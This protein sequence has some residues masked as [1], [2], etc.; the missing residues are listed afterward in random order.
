VSVRE[1]AGSAGWTMGR[2]PDGC[3]DEKLPVAQARAGGAVRVRGMDDANSDE[4][5]LARDCYFMGENS[6]ESMKTDSILRTSFPLASVSFRTL[7]HS[8][9]LRNASQFFFAASRPGCART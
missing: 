4:I 1:S 7:C 3:Q 9:S 8:G 6:V 2:R 5:P